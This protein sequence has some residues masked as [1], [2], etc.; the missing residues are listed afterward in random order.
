MKLA[1]EEWCHCLEG[2]AHPFLVL[3][4]HKN[5]EYLKTAKRFNSRQSWWALF[6]TRFQF[7]LAYHP[8]SRNTK[9]D[10]LSCQYPNSGTSCESEPIIFSN[11]TI[12][13]T[14]CTLD[15]LDNL[16]EAVNRLNSTAS[17]NQVGRIITPSDSS[18][19]SPKQE[20]I[21][22]SQPPSPHP[23]SLPPPPRFKP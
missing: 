1:L 14:Q 7:I 17:G 12:N 18:E 20:R 23:V 16:N 15:L 2:A 8:G 19:A 4:D 5:L 6:F 13:E 3:I 22:I 10:T 9:A 21:N 11:N